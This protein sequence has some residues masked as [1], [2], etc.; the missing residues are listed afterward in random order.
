MARNAQF[1]ANLYT[2]REDCGPVEGWIADLAIQHEIDADARLSRQHRTHSGARASDHR[3][4]ADARVIER[5]AK[6]VRGVAI[7]F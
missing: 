3:L 7:I 2:R 1:A 4:P 5:H 6:A